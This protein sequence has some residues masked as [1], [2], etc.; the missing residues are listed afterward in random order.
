MIEGM[1]EGMIEWNLAFYH[2]HSSLEKRVNIRDKSGYF[3][4]ESSIKMGE[5]NAKK[6]WGGGSRVERVENWC[7]SW[8]RFT[9]MQ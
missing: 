2:Y 6:C 1:L 9:K 5:W 3:E 8:V 7:K 4:M